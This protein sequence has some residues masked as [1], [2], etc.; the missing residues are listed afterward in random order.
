MAAVR[1]RRQSGNG[2]TGHTIRD[3]PWMDWKAMTTDN[4][5][6]SMTRASGADCRDDEAMTARKWP[7]RNV[8]RTTRAIIKVCP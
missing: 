7:N 8:E 6:R 3:E 1:G 4:G 5:G 2:S